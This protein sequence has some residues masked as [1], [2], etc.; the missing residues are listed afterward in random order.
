MRL[1]SYTVV[2][3]TGFAPNPFGRYCT[4]AACTPNHQG[5]KLS[6]GDLQRCEINL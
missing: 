5:I 1:C 2:H 6:Q 3:G 4:L